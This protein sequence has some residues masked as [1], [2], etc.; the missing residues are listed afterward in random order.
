MDEEAALLSL[1]QSGP[2][3]DEPLDRLS[4]AEKT[5]RVVWDLEAQVNNGG[6]EQY[7]SSGASDGAPHVEDALRGLGATQCA[8]IV[9]QAIAT[10]PPGTDLGDADAIYD[11]VD[12]LVQ[13]D[14]NVF[15]AIDAAFY[16][17]PDD[18]SGLLYA[19]VVAYRE[20]IR[21]SLDLAKYVEVGM[22]IMKSRRAAARHYSRST[23]TNAR[24]SINPPDGS[25][26]AVTNAS[27][28]VSRRG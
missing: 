1:S 24:S 18:L 12:A 21:G 3:W 14:E 20:S 28:A 4:P 8:D 16:D 5:F 22:L 13:A 25:R 6:F 10:L 7:F 9:A 11:A 26:A 19:H 23:S 2:F 15:A 27:A 17:Y